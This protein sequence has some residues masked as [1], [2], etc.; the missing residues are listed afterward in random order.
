M[1]FILHTVKSQHMEIGY[2]HYYITWKTEYLYILIFCAGGGRKCYRKKN[3]SL[4][5]EWEF[6]IVKTMSRGDWNTRLT[7]SVKWRMFI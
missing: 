7:N 5:T 2:K 3:R 6:H 1:W 4:D